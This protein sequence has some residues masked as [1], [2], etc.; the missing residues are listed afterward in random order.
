[1]IQTYVI[2][3]SSAPEKFNNLRSQASRIGLSLKRID[4]V[5]GKGL[6]A[7]DIDSPADE[8]FWGAPGPHEI[9]CFLSHK[10]AWIEISMSNQAWGLVLEDDVHLSSCLTDFLSDTHWIPTDADIIKIEAYPH[11]RVT[12]TRWFKRVKH[13]KLLKIQSS[14]LG[15]G[16]YF[17]SKNFCRRLLRNNFK[18]D[19]PI[20]NYL[21]D[22]QT[23]G[24]KNRI[25]YAIEPALVIQDQ[26]LADNHPKFQNYRSIIEDDRRS[27]IY[28]VNTHKTPNSKKSFLRHIIDFLNRIYKNI[29]FKIN[30]Q[31]K[32]GLSWQ[33]CDFC[34]KEI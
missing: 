13:R 19:M 4:A 11:L 25:I 34:S 27:R 2:N 32:N 24:P 9:G 18:I 1:M 10:L 33:E 15:T 17:I 3:L 12:H 7:R 30:F 28:T 20:D 26:F 23:F 14:L 16:G 21:F 31:K 8:G 5:D 29:V 6:S 22:V